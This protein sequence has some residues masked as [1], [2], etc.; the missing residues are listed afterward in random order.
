MGKETNY[1]DDYFKEG[2]GNADLVPP[3]DVWE[4]IEKELDRKRRF[5][6]FTI[7]AGLAAGL[8]LFIGVGSY[9]F[10]DSKPGNGLI[11]KVEK[12]QEPDHGKQVS[13]VIK[14]SS[15]V[16]SSQ[17]KSQSK[18]PENKQET[19]S[20][21]VTANK[22]VG[23]PG[24]F[25]TVNALQKSGSEENTI[26]KDIVAKREDS[27]NVLSNSVVSENTV[28]QSGA[29]FNTKEKPS[30][31]VPKSIQLSVV[32]EK[33][34]VISQ[35]SGNA[36]N[37]IVNLNLLAYTDFVDPEPKKINRWSIEGQVAPQYSYRTISGVP[38]GT[39]TKTQFNAQ[40]DGLVAYAGG[41]KVSYETSSRFSIQIGVVYSVMGQTLNDVYSVSQS[42]ASNGDKILSSNAESYW[43]S[44]SLGPI[45]NH[46]SSGIVATIVKTVQSDATTYNNL[47]NSSYTTQALASAN[48]SDVQLI[49]QQSYIEIP[50]LAR[51]TIIDKKVG[52]H[53]VGGVSTNVL[54]GNNVFAKMGNS[55]ENIGETGNLR[56]LNYNGDF[57]FGINYKLWKKTMLTIEPTFKYYLN[58]ITDKAEITYHPYSFGIYT[59]IRYKF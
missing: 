21:A 39:L 47:V 37:T 57:G 18:E 38:S 3:A 48:K 31:I 15:P 11:T 50:L 19:L 8:A 20:N 33:K 32:P 36:G 13:M 17:K 28:S 24:N 54:V 23:Q 55:T 6:L 27:N 7:W 58:S 46:S 52:V 22:T 29:N 25:K 30:F 49:Q 56:S 41:I 1:I 53:L 16:V 42:F 59:G 26:G 51:Y 44:N 4:N 45:T 14:N 35:S 9:Y 34:P 43:A 40:E 2:L 10:F 12:K 5:G